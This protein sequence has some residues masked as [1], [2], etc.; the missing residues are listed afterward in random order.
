LVLWR[1]SCPR[2][3]AVDVLFCPCPVAQPAER[4]P[5][6]TVSNH[7]PGFVLITRDVPA[8]LPHNKSD[9]SRRQHRDPFAPE[10]N[11]LSGGASGGVRLGQDVAAEKGPQRHRDTEKAQGGSEKP[12]GAGRHQP[13][14]QPRRQNTHG[15]ESANRG[16]PMGWSRWPQFMKG[17]GRS[18]H[19]SCNARRNLVDP[20]PTTQMVCPQIAPASCR[21]GR[22]RLLIQTTP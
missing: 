12:D 1:A 16:A 11:V 2:G 19:D 17:R 10:E 8:C 13:P 5:S 21:R 15:S 18:R 7:C 9:S 22:S 14:C 4:P 3:F 6:A 20:V